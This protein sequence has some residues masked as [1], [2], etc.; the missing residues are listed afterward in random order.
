M[1][2]IMEIWVGFEMKLS[3]SLRKIIVYKTMNRRLSQIIK[4]LKQ[5]GELFYFK[6][7]SKYKNWTVSELEFQMKYNSDRILFIRSKMLEVK[8]GS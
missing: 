6:S 7:G 3:K 8:R 1:A 5:E 4:H 2:V